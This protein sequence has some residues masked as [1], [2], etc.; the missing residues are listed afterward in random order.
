MGK[1]VVTL[2]LVGALPFLVLIFIAGRVW[3]L[4]L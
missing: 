1:L 4:E 3:E 2:L